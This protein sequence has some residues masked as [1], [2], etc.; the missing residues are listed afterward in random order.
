MNN[1]RVGSLGVLL[2][3]SVGFGTAHAEPPAFYDT[4]SVLTSGAP[5]ELI[6]SE[7]MTVALDPVAHIP[8]PVRAWRMLYA[9]TGSGG[10]SVPASGT[11]LVPDQPWTGPGPRPLVDAASVTQGLDRSCATSINLRNGIAYEPVFAAPL[12]ARGWAVAITDWMGLG[13]NR[14]HTYV[15][16]LDQ[17]HTFVDVARAA[18]TVPGAGLGPDTPIGFAG[19]AYG[20]VGVAGALEMPEYTVGLNIVGASVGEPLTSFGTTFD[21]IWARDDNLGYD[22][23]YE[24][25]GLIAAY[26]EQAE[27]IRSILNDQGR[28]ILDETRHQCQIESLAR[29]SGLPTRSLTADGRSLKEHFHE[30][31]FVS[32]L[33]E[34]NLGTGTPT[35][36]VFVV[37]YTADQV[38]SVP[39]ARDLVRRWSDAGASVTYRELR[40]PALMPGSLLDHGTGTAVAMEGGI[41]YLADRFAGRPVG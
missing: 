34:Q 33:A 41:D 31:P 19:S 30:E 11:L 32:L 18:L 27:R 28:S 36:P 8:M 1:R 35:V 4:P 37:Q 9:S 17:T 22:A 23:P 12:L 26:P 15:N 2:A 6:R 20:A 5:G 3:F 13:A 25:N 21:N 29:Y 16:K 38:I 40:G 39:Q 14:E 7:P 10:E 24:M